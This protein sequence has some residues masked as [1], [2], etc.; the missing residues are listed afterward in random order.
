MET[1]TAAERIKQNK[2]RKIQILAEQKKNWRKKKIENTKPT[3]KNQIVHEKLM[4][5]SATTTSKGIDHLTV[6]EGNL[7]LNFEE[8]YFNQGEIK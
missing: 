4:Q 3:G 6:C 8:K 1:I 5:F 2:L 7:I